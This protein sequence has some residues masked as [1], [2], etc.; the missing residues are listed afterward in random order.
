MTG[1]SGHQPKLEEEV[2]LP[3]IINAP[4]VGY[5]GSYRGKNIGKLG[6]CE[7][8]RTRL[9]VWEKDTV[10]GILGVPA[11]EDDWEFSHYTNSCGNFSEKKFHE[12]PSDK[13]AQNNHL[14]ASSSGTWGDAN[15]SSGA[16]FG[17]MHGVREES[18]ADRILLQ[19]QMALESRY[20]TATLARSALKSAFFAVDRPR[21]GSLPVGLFFDVL[22]RQSGC[23]LSAAQCAHLAET[24][25]MAGR[26]RRGA[27]T[28][29]RGPDYALGSARLEDEDGYGDGA[30]QQLGGEVA[31]AAEVCYGR[32]LNIVVPRRTSKV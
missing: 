21:T 8:H 2:E 16:S 19:V 3:K 27:D 4:V 32:F 18:E 7:V 26:H 5:T 14:A 11:P 12:S 22:H 23:A 31:A 13:S 24:L 15:T 9:T 1:Y 28:E 6:R 17:A 10:S 25:H 20:K 30:D 29:A